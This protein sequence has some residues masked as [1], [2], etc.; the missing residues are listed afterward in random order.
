VSFRYIFN[1]P[2]VNDVTMPEI[3]TSEQ[4]V[5]EPGV[6]SLSWPLKSWKDIN[7]QVLTTVWQNRS[8]HEVQINSTGNTK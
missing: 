3:R 1:V 6:L 7:Y 2:G 8:T 5:F 4:L